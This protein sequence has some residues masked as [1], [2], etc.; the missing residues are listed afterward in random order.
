MNLMTM[1][2]NGA[3]NVSSPTAVSRQAALTS[4]SG[5]TSSSR[6]SRADSVLAV[7]RLQ[8]P[9]A[10]A[11]VPMPVSMVSDPVYA[12]MQRHRTAYAV[13]ME[14]W[15]RTRGGLLLEGEGEKSRWYDIGT[16]EED[17]FN[18]LLTTKPTTKSG[19][20]ACV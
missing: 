8:R 1:F 12:A 13:L 7:E 10:N 11:L 18:V 3:W 16:A 5:I 17:A 6:R 14:E 15:K 2:S 4:T 9:K 20:M 19:A